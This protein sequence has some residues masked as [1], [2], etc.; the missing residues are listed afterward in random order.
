[1]ANIGQ[2]MSSINFG[3]IIGGSLNALVEA[4]SQAAYTTVDFINSVGFTTDQNGNRNPTYVSFYYNKEVPAQTAD[5][6]TG[7]EPTMETQNMLLKV[8]LL[9]MLP[10]PFIRI[11]DATID[12]NVKINSV[13]TTS[14]SENS[15]YG[16]SADVSMDF[17]FW[18]FKTSA[19]LN[20]SLSNQKA[21]SAT[22]EVKRDYS[23]NIHIRAVQD[24]MPAGTERL[25]D[26]LGESISAVH[27]DPNA[28]GDA[29]SAKK[30][31][32]PAPA[33]KS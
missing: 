20:A 13:N 1:M 4:Q 27:A 18:R 32:A 14:N 11:E 6:E 21:S 10:I 28:T 25:L 17:S 31:Q 24:Q 2:E 23:L 8:P 30:K 16:G 29:D 19:K 33:A 26:F 3:S 12:F 7:T 15:S 9:T 5:G 22:E